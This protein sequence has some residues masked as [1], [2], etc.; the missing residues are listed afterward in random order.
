MEGTQISICKE[1][2]TC[3]AD[4][5]FDWLPAAGVGT[6]PYTKAL[7]RLNNWQTSNRRWGIHSISSS[8][9]NTTLLTTQLQAIS[10]SKRG[11]SFNLF[12]FV[13]VEVVRISS[14]CAK[15]PKKSPWILRP[16]SLILD[17]LVEGPWLN[18]TGRGTWRIPLPKRRLGTLFT[19]TLP[20]PSQIP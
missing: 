3:F 6:P 4:M 9:H 16:R 2:S 15:A 20:L 17:Q 18:W 14:A 13:L 11:N 8:N 1:G 5:F 19:L 10:I 12:S 7:D